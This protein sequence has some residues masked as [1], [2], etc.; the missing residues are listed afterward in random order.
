LYFKKGSR[1]LLHARTRIQRVSDAKLFNAWVTLF[2]EDR[3]GVAM[4]RIPEMEPGQRARIE[5]YDVGAVYS[6]E[7][8][9]CGTQATHAVF[10]IR[11]RFTERPNEEDPRLLVY[12]ISGGIGPMPEDSGEESRRIDV[13]GV[14]DISPQGIGLLAPL[15]YR[16][17]SRVLVMI[18]GQAGRV[19]CS[20]EVRYCKP[21][22]PGYRIGVK[23]LAMDRLSRAIYEQLLSGSILVSAPPH[24]LPESASLRRAA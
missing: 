18:K 19:E 5:V 7:A 14:S 12:H 3:V 21:Q 23:I 17:G 2:D 10:Q 20:A 24:S 16:K 6:F 11:S 22:G 13:C 8:V 9:F 15:P 4:S 1:K